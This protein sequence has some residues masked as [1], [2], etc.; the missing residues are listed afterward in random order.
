MLITLTHLPTVTA[1]LDKVRE[2][3]AQCAPGGLRAAVVKCGDLAGRKRCGPGVYVFFDE[4]WVYYV[5]ESADVCRRLGEH[6][7]AHIGGSE[8]VVRF[9]AYLLDR[10]CET[11][12][13]WLGKPPAEVERWLKERLLKPFI[14]G[15][16]IYVAS[17]EGI[18]KDLLRGVEKCLRERLRPL[19]NPA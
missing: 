3:V 17:G 10:A 18:G 9:L 19:L 4:E 12:G 6:C 7:E 16:N 13:E 8:G 15:L 1:V 11:R 5:G 14:H 2:A